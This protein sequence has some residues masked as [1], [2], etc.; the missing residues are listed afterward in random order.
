MYD[1]LCLDS[2]KA[3][4]AG[5]QLDWHLY[6]VQG[7]QGHTNTSLLCP[8]TARS[9]ADWCIFIAQ[10]P[11]VF[12][13]IMCLGGGLGNRYRIE[14]ETIYLFPPET[15]SSKLSLSL[16]GVSQITRFDH[17]ALKDLKQKLQD[18]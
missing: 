8:E 17:V 11:A 7:Q 2:T 16:E 1:M 13:Y 10:K 14:S 15:R 18:S 9:Q 4:V 5:G 6:V 3:T 12:K